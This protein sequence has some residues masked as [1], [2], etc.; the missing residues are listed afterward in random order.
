MK[1]IIKGQNLIWSS[2]EISHKGDGPSWIVMNG[3][4]Y[5]YRS[6]HIHRE[7]GPAVEYANGDKLWYYNGNRIECS[8]QE[9]FE[10]LLKLKAFW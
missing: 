10:R 9:E 4:K 6:G 1:G 7:D 8:S 5:W 2:P 3:N